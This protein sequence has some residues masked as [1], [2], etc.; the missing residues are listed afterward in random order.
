MKFDVLY[1]WFLADPRRPRY[2]GTL[3]LVEGGKG[4]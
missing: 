1:L 3:R 2:V 4:V